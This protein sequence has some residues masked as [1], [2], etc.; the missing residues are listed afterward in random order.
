[1]RLE[2]AGF[3]HW[4]RGQRQRQDAIGDFARDY[5]GDSCM[6]GIRTLSGID[7]HLRAEHGHADKALAARDRAWR[8]FRAG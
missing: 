5:L 1:M 3:R 4:L 7:R 2:H 6:V 8:A